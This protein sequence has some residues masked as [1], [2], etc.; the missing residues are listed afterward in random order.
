MVFQNYALFPHLSVRRNIAFGL[1]MRRLP[2]AEVRRRTDDAI[3]LVRLGEHA[4]KLPGQ[5]SGGQ[6]QRVAIARAVVLEPSLVL[7][8]EP[9]SNLDAKLRLEMRTEIRR[10]H[11]SLGLTTVYVTHDQEEAL[12]MA[13]RLVVLR[14]GR[15]QQTGTPEELHT[16][17]ANRHVADFMGY[18]NLL[19]MTVTGATGAAVTVTAGDLTV[20][21]TPMA[22]LRPGDAVVAAI[23]PEDLHP[24]EGV[25]ATVEVVE[26]QGREFAVEARTGDGT[27]L[28]LRAAER[29]SAGD[30]ITVA[31]DPSRILVYPA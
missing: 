4:A 22:A 30:K 24:G 15:V 1:R 16:R 26:Y 11:Q 5:L 28:H 25:P 27:R 6:Q 29:P 13:D 23:R 20:T 14:D 17:P 12:S 19:P 18:R 8:D 9:L 2:R 10:L 31:A 7:M 21:G 3:R